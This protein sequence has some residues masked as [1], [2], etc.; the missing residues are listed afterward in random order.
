[1][2]SSVVSASALVPR[3]AGLLLWFFATSAAAQA[4]DRY[5]WKLEDTIDGC[6]L[7][8]SKVSGKAYIAAQS[9]C[10]V[11]ANIEV[12]GA[13]LRDIEH[14]PEWMQDCSQTKM[15]KVVDR[16]REIYVFWFRQHITLFTDRDMVLKSE[17][18]I[19]E[20][21]RR[22]IKANS[23]SD[24]AYDSGKGYIRM[25]SFASEWVLEKLDEQKTRV[26]FMIDPDLAE[27]LPV[28]IAN[29]KIKK[30]PFKSIRGLMKMAK[31]QKYIDRAKDFVSAKRA[32]ETAKSSEP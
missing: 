18:T 21:G 27:G 14:Y 29:S 17:L 25:P 10:V 31:L 4:P 19:H 3:T 7:N 15:L 32:A 1:M 11:P 28:G 12:V 13:V 22:V 30:T 6:Q 24:E 20:E 9:V 2:L 23:T 5:S 8:T 16:G 26:S